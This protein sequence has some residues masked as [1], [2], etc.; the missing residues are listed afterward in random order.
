MLGGW[1]RAFLLLFLTMMIDLPCTAG[2]SNSRRQPPIFHGSGVAG[3]GNGRG[4]FR[5]I[6]KP[7][8][9]KLPLDKSHRRV[10]FS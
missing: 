6:G 3:G 1:S 5:E 8:R 4:V 10:Y 9:A 2:L 7:C